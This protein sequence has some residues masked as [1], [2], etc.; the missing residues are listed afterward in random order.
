[1]PVEIGET[2][3]NSAR[4]QYRVCVGLMIK[5]SLFQTY[6]QLTFPLRQNA[7]DDM[8]V[9]IGETTTNSIMIEG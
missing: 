3:P 2:P 5:K 4:G 7:I 1:M 9:E 8:P 6:K